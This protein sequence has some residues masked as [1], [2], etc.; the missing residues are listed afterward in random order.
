[1]IA[2][3]IFM[4]LIAPLAVEVTAAYLDPDT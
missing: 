3:C 4:T 2:L 1:V